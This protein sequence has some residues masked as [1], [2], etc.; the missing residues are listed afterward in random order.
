MLSPSFHYHSSLPP[1]GYWDLVFPPF[2]SC[3]LSPLIAWGKQNVV[4]WS[5]QKEKWQ[6][7]FYISIAL[8]LPF[9]F[10]MDWKQIKE[11]FKWAKPGKFM[12]ATLRRFK[13]MLIKE[14]RILLIWL[15]TGTLKTNGRVFIIWRTVKDLAILFHFSDYTRC[16][17]WYGS[18]RVKRNR[19]QCIWTP[20]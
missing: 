14:T 3:W 18:W 10:S 17:G 8:F 20:P 1:S 12:K 16:V 5:N 2:S 19:H 13:F 6:W 15:D 7:S 9:S 4:E 11:Y